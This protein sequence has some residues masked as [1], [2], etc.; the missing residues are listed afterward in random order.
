MKALKKLL[1]FIIVAALLFF[2]GIKLAGIIN[3]KISEGK[4]P[5]D[6]TVKNEVIGTSTFKE[7]TLEQAFS[8]IANEIAN[9][10]VEETVENKEVLYNKSYLVKN[11]QDDEAGVSNKDCGLKLNKNKNFNFYLG[12]GASLFGDFEIVGDELTCHATYFDS[13]A[14]GTLKENIDSYLVFTITAED[15]LKLKEIRY[16]SSR[17]E[18]LIY[19]DGLEDGEEYKAK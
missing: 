4:E 15:E 9:E 7:E 1:V 18:D 11:P 13:K 17:D 5:E 8:E 2:V 16:G 19:L 12:W 14:E 10:V 3:S 6:N